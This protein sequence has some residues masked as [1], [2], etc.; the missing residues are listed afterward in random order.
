MTVRSSRRWWAGVMILGFA[1]AQFISLAHACMGGAEMMQP[2]GVAA[3]QA[4]AMPVDC[5]MLADGAP[6]TDTRCDAH[7]VPGAQADRGADVRIEAL[8]PPGVLVVRVV[9][10]A[11]AN[12]TRA[13]PPLARIASP[14]LSLLFRR[15]LI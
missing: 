2:A 13:M 1:C 15:F 5:P 9:F 12:A 8:A 3:Q 4:G 7:C 10:P 6:A 11:V 14:P